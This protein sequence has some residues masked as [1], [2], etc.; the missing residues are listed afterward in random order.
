M[1]DSTNKQLKLKFKWE[2]KYDLRGYEEQLYKEVVYDT[3]PKNEPSNEQEFR[4]MNPL[5]KAN[6]GGTRIRNLD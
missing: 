4:F 6:K 2:H 1:I 3:R 5:K